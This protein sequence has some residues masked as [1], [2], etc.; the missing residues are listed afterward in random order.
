MIRLQ[1]QGGEIPNLTSR[2]PAGVGGG[3][4]HHLIGT[5]AALRGSVSYVTGAHNM[6]FGYQGGFSNPSQTYTFFNEIIHI[7]TNNGVP[8]RLT[9]TISGTPTGVKF[10][11]NLLP[12]SFYGQDQFTTGRLTLQG[13]IRY[14]HLTTNYPDSGMGGPGFAASAPDVIFYPK[15][16]TPGIDWDDVTARMG[17]AYDL[18]GNG[19]TALKFNLGKYMEAFVASNSDFDL[20]P[21]IRTTV[22]TTRVW[23]DT[24]KDFVANCDLANTEHRTA[25]AATCRTT[26]S[27]KRCSSAATIRTSSPALATAPTAGRWGC[28]CSRSSCPASR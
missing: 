26:P 10:V 27:G 14:D 24:N 23:T 21:L 22:S 15:G 16:S 11:R 18:F 1:E 19:K 28:R 17:V 3:F 2:M 13:G 6:K 12:T 20:N 7:R 25:N 9:Q 5:I 8:N 4:N